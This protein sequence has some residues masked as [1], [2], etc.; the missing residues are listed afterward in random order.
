MIRINTALDA[1]ANNTELA[2]MSEMHW[3]LY[4]T[5][6]INQTWTDEAIIYLSPSNTEP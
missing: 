2:R 6:C 1:Q 3:I 5:K 4:Y